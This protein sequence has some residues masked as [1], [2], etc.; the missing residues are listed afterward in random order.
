MDI[1]AAFKPFDI[2]GQTGTVVDNRFAFVLGKTLSLDKH[3]KKVLVACD[4]RPTSTALKAFLAD[5]FS[6]EK[7]KIFDLGL[8]PVPMFYWVMCQCWFDLGVMVTASH[9]SDK[10]SG[11]KLVNAD[12]L[13]FNQSEIE[14]LKKSMSR[15]SGSGIVVP[16]KEIF[17]C[18]RMDDYVQA[19]IDSA[20]KI[21]SSLK[22]VL[23][24]TN[25]S[26]AEAVKK[27]F[28]G[29]EINYRIAETKNTGNPLLEENRRGLATRVRRENA[30]IGIIW[31]S[32]GDRVAFVGSDGELIPMTFVLGL[33]A[34]EEVKARAGSK[35]A[36][37]VRAGLVV[38]DLVTQAGGKLEVTPAW[39]QNFKFAMR[40]DP[41]IVFGG[42]TSGHFVFKCFFGI[43]DGIFAALKFLHL[44][45][46]KETREKLKALEKKYFELPEKNFP[47]PEGKSSEVLEKLSEYY[48]KK[49]YDISI[50]DGLSVFGQDF[51]F[52]LRSSLTEP[53]L[54]LNLEAR[55]EKRAGEIISDIEYHI[56]I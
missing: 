43:D 49:S 16:K 38:R 36:V 5:G 31:D 33:L 2:R 42:E 15:H 8:A 23:D 50:V 39:S 51:K 44:W 30:D 35:V 27:V 47:C 12:G 19:V 40:E 28:S 22:V 17:P 1:E 46:K 41:Q 37:D 34:T 21:F 55:S 26:A 24:V 29:I 56:D 9:V 10:E 45:G 7:T 6:T 4:S 3:P 54:R 25:S 32:D 14:D 20:P 53:Y 11:F 48:R 13:P 18:E 52:N